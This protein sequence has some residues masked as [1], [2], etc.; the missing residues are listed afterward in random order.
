MSLSASVCPG[1]TRTLPRAKQPQH[2][3]HRL[4]SIRFPQIV[5]LSISNKSFFEDL[6]FNSGF[7]CVMSFSSPSG[8]VRNW[9]ELLVTSSG[10]TFSFW[11]T[12]W[13]VTDAD[14]FSSMER[15]CEDL[16][17]FCDLLDGLPGVL[18]GGGLNSFSSILASFTYWH[19]FPNSTMLL[20]IFRDI[21]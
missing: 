17:L 4:Q 11:W 12:G 1:S 6:C 7:S 18:A 3:S 19:D 8:V 5:N 16:H 20:S 13:L 2:T 9:S 21:N 14:R 15:P 10:V